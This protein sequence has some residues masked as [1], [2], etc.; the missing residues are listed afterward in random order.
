MASQLKS[1]TINL[2]KENKLLNA[3]KKKVTKYFDCLHN[4]LELREFQVVRQID[5]EQKES[6]K[7]IDDLHKSVHIL[8]EL[9][10]MVNDHK[11]N[12]RSLQSDGQINLAH[13]VKT[14]VEEEG[15]AKSLLQDIE[16]RSP[17]K[18]ST[19]PKLLNIFKSYIYVEDTT[20]KDDSKT[21]PESSNEDEGEGNRVFNKLKEI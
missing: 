6:L 13:V 1:K 14:M 20:V 3:E 19:D 7:A 4:S 9:L 16:A 8:E 18:L 5:K 11:I 2:E 17:N 10:E 21:P 15:K 12:P